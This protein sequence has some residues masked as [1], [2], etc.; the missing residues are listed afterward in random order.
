MFEQH[1]IGALRVRIENTRPD[2][3]SADVLRRLA[4]ALDLIA[5]YAPRR[6]RR[7]ERDLIGI[8]VRRF[9]CRGAFFHQEREC[10][11][12]LTFTVNPR[13]SLAEIAASIVHEATH[14][15]IATVCG[16]LPQNRRAREE[17]LCR[18]AELEFGLAIPDGHVVVE[19]ASMALDMADQDVAPTVDWTEGARRVAA[20]DARANRA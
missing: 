8:V 20:A 18:K 5:T 2:I 16:P 15:R 11:V 14:A 17:R 3:D 1:R 9:P 19:R 13:H 4:Q 10:L 6:L 7:M 12:E